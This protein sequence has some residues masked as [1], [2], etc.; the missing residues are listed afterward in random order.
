LATEVGDPETAKLAK[1]IRRDEERMAKFLE[2]ELGRLVKEV[3][4]AEIPRDQRANGGRRTRGRTTRTS[5]SASRSGARSR[6]GRARATN[7]QPS[8]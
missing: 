2:A 7:R 5:R 8:A 1:E 6:L 4:R 3:V